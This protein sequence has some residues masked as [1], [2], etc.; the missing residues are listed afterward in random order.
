MYFT[1]EQLE[2]FEDPA[3]YLKFRKELEGSFFRG[4]DGQLKES[5]ASKSA[6]KNFLEAMSRRLAGDEELLA[7]LIPDFPPNCRRLTPGPGYLEALRAPNVTF[8]QT[9][10]ERYGSCRSERRLK[11]PDFVLQIHIIRNRDREWDSQRGKYPNARHLVPNTRR[12]SADYNQVDAVIAS[13]GANVD[14]A[15][16]FPIEANGFDLSRDWKADGK[17]GW[18]YS[19]LGLCTPGTASSPNV[20]K[21]P[22]EAHKLTYTR[23]TGLP[24]LAFLLGSHVHLRAVLK[25]VADK[26]F[27][28]RTLL[29]QVAQFP[30]LLRRRSHTS[31]KC[32]GKCRR[33]VFVA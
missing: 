17:F 25:P 10:I 23:A 6:K 9:P 3:T 27:Q 2:A 16:P 32:S 30:T 11:C 13:T 22:S 12:I 33:S 18:P 21:L 5:E 26:S 19:Y 28:D 14:Y 31:L 7:K 4:F 15:P 8:V 29:V 20:T 1:P 24:N